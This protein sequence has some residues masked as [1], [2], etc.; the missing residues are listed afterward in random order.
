MNTICRTALVA[1][2]CMSSSLT[3]SAETSGDGE[4]PVVT[5]PKTDAPPRIDG[6]LSDG[7]WRRAFVFTA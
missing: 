6:T 1:L 7:E 5:V 3:A 4:P 2:L